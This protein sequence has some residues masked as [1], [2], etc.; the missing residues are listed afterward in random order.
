MQV[1][2]YLSYFFLPLGLL[3]ASGAPP[4][5]YTRLGFTEQG[6]ASYYANKFHGRQTACGERFNMYAMTAAHKKLL[7]H[8]L[9]EVTNKRNGRSIVVRINDRGPYAHGRIIDLSKAAAEKLD[10][11]RDGVTDVSIRVLRV[12]KSGPTL[13]ESGK[14]EPQKPSEKDRMSGK[15]KAGSRPKVDVSKTKGYGGEAKTR[16]YSLWGKPRKP[17]GFGV[18]V[19]S[20]RDLKNAVKLGKEIF[21]KG[22][23]RIYI[24]AGWSNGKRIYRVMVGEGSKTG[25]A[26]TALKLRIKGYKNGFIKQFENY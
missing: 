24:Q 1:R 10:M 25:T 18:Q 13:P 4:S 9:V 19:G 15:D 14:V 22:F 26:A 17:Q 3:L 2:R 6:E 16:Y 20:Y 11:I 5:A 23:N 7:F 8:S 21:R 12:G